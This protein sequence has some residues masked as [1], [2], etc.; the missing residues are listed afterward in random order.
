M[1]VA[2]VCGWVDGAERHQYQLDH[3]QGTTGARVTRHVTLPSVT[4]SPK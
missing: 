2:T 4:G 3:H 1:P